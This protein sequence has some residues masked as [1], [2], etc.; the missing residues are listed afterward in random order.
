MSINPRLAYT[1]AEAAEIMG[2][3][4]A[5]VYRYLT[6]GTLPSLKIGRARRIRAE[7]L[8]GFLDRLETAQRSAGDDAA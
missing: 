7:A 8:H 2:V 1:P 5:T 4:R 3:G 6:D